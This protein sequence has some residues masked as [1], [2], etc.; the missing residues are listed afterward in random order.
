M[1]ASGIVAAIPVDEVERE[2]AGD[3]AAEDANDRL[4]CEYN[5]EN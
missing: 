5:L 3:I 1:I 2:L 4:A